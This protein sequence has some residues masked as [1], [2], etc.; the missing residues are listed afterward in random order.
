MFASPRRRR[1]S[2]LAAPF[3]W[4]RAAL[5]LLPIIT[6]LLSLPARGA[7]F[8]AAADQ[9]QTKTLA[10]GLQ[11][12]VW[13]VH[14][15][16]N[17]VL[18]NWVRVGSRNESTGATGLAHFFE[19][20]M[21]NG[22]TDH[23]KGDFERLLG[24]AGGSSNA[25]TRKDVTVFQDWFPR[26]ALETVLMLESDRI[27][28][29]AFVP[30]VVENE[31]KVVYSERRLRVEDSAPALL[32]EQLEAVAL[33]AHPYRIPTIGWPSDIQSWT[34]ADL[35]SFYHTFYAPNNCTLVIVGDVEPAALFAL[36]ERYFGGIP[37]GALPE[38]VRTRE[39]EQLGERRL[40]LHRAAE[41]GLVQV[42]YPALSAA[43]PRQSALDLL[44]MILT[45]GE[46]SRLHRS[47]VEERRLAIE[48][49]SDWS[50]GLDPSLLGFYATLA[51]GATSAQFEQALEEELERVV[52]EGVSEAELSRAKRQSAVAF[53][54]G[55]TTLDGRA[56]LL[57]EY[58]LMH[59]DYR[60]LF[61]APAA[62]ER[63]SRADVQAVA[64]QILN[65]LHRTI[66]ELVPEPAGAGQ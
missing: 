26:S 48:V 30:D 15:I 22:T 6:L 56:E 49:D 9:V 36:I 39:P 20:M 16:P 46:S 52:H 50:E 5:G 14:N 41:T 66:G 43:D 29:L 62:L 57:G 59:G 21:F 42:L 1:L 2:Q 47:L 3:Y 23:P 35:E 19:H 51:E 12:I 31:R 63:V 17:I 38:P 18:Y 34:L 4:A 55:V 32:S 33:L 40:Q 24:E 7:D 54:R 28:H 44:Q 27:A 61:A 25:N 10:N 37:R 8:A 13:P 53:W 65:P 60:L 11:V 64:Q 58:A 45:G